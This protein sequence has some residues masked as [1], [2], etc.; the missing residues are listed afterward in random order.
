MQR[1][2]YSKCNFHEQQ[3]QVKGRFKNWLEAVHV[4]LREGAQVMS[5]VN[6]SELQLC[7]TP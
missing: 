3:I 7:F 2:I 5:R 4:G 6:P 1:L